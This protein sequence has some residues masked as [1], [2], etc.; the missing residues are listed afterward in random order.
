MKLKLFQLLKSVKN[1][2]YKNGEVIAEAEER[3]YFGKV[4]KNDEGNKK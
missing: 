4:I 1:W 2:I 3:F